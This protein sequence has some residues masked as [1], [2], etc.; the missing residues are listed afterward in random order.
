M[1][2]FQQQLLS[3]A[4]SVLGHADEQLLDARLDALPTG[5]NSEVRDLLV[6]AFEA[7]EADTLRDFFAPS[8]FTRW[9]AETAT[10]RDEQDLHAQLAL[11]LGAHPGGHDDPA[12]LSHVEPPPDELE[13]LLLWARPYGLLGELSQPVR[14]VLSEL[15]FVGDASLA[16]CLLGDVQTE[17]GGGKGLL[18]RPDVQTTARKYAL[19]QAAKHAALSAR[20]ELW[21]RRSHPALSK[22]AQRLHAV[23]G[24]VSFP[25]LHSVAFLPAKPVRLE[26]ATGVARAYVRG[27]ESGSIIDLRAFLSGYEQRAISIDCNGCRAR[28]CVHRRALA[29]RLL[30][31]CHDTGDALQVVLLEFVRIP[32]WQRF[33][34]EAHGAEEV[35]SRSKERVVF[36]I[37]IEGERASVGMLVQRMTP[38]GRFSQGKLAT[39]SQVTRNHAFE[40]RDRPVL[41]VL[42]NV[43][44]TLSA[45]FVVADLTLLRALVDHPLVFLD[46]SGESVRLSERSVEVELLEQ[47]E[48]LLPKVTLAGELVP[49]GARAA[50]VTY[51]MR[52][53]GDDL[54]FAA[55][56]PSLRRLL[57]ALDHFRGV[58]PPESYP[59]VA[60]WL[61]S[62]QAVAQVHVPK[63][64]AGHERPQLR[65][66]LLR[67][68]PGRDEGID[69]AIMVRALSLAALWLPG[70]GPELVHGFEDEKQAYV[71]RD[72]AWEREAAQRLIE[73]LELSRFVRLDPYAYRVE[74]RQEALTLLSRA[75]RLMEVL[76]IEWSER[77]RKLTLMTR[78]ATS[79][80]KVSL[81]RKGQWLSIEGKLQV[82]G[83]ELSVERLLEAV[84]R[85]ERFV[86]VQGN[87]YLEIEEQLFDRLA[88]AQL[89]TPPGRPSQLSVLAAPLWLKTVGDRSEAGDEETKLL[90]DRLRNTSNV[91]APLPVDF[92]PH[93]RS[94]QREGV[95]WLV[96]RSGWAPGVCLADEMGLGKTIQAAAL[97][98]LRG[99][100]GPALVITPTS[101][102]S[103]WVEA[104]TRFAP[105]LRAESYVGENRRAS[106]ENLSAQAVLVVSYETLLRD[107]EHFAKVAFATQVIDEAQVIRNARTLRAKAVAEVTAAFRVALSGTPVENR[108]GDLW[109]LFHLLTPG[110]LGPWSQFRARFAVPIERY[111]NS[112][113]S[114][115]LRALVRPFLLRRTKDE[116]ATE[117]PSRT[118]VIH[119]IE[120]SPAERDLY[121]AAERTARKALG[122]RSPDQAA[123][124][125]QILAEL[126]KLR[127]LSCHPRLVIGDER[128]GSSK[129]AAFLQLTEDI[130][131]RGH[132][133][134]VFSQFTRHLALVRQA[135]DE[136]A[137]TSLYL[138]GSTPAAERPG[139]VERFQN[140][141][142][143]VFLISLKAGGT[144]LNLTNADY[145][146]HMDPW[147]NPAAEDQASDRAHRIG[148]TKPL[149]IVKLVSE[150]TIEERVL[151]LHEHKRRLA[152][153]V[154]AGSDVPFS[155]DATDLEALLAG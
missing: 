27:S 110:L 32:S 147:W 37:R 80:L 23:V 120:L 76:D 62:L 50:D 74:S 114:D 1:S 136:A 121:E 57:A 97:L 29:A 133:V 47:P 137:V 93:L 53:H 116:V 8:T 30:D 115:A 154:L 17:P 117:L 60:P 5:L 83:A 96:E 135:L 2:P 35:R 16:A 84:V 107:R 86:Q 6:S 55:L 61:A 102:T 126:T 100:S 38:E 88:M 44:R 56:T 68:T 130:L 13:A 87:D 153:T 63:A 51:L 31:A 11:W 42:G 71:R 12:R 118:E 128:V 7:G 148:Q 150:G 149:T 79:D 131:R 112:E 81:F 21:K 134:L 138:D 108:L 3:M 34:R 143:D 139:L 106:L 10:Q 43:Q 155:V 26:P 95:A 67:V 91:G 145:V 22:L 45:R 98:A 25:T 90:L 4:A 9:L 151:A 18:S 142:A 123:R 49:Y 85:G 75:A 15:N 52:Q 73:A 122:K 144:G 77:S 103:Q 33:L 146:I 40:E 19:E 105:T 69:V 48:G 59:S 64:L 132:R 14:E 65:K 92:A 41:D 113:R 152:Q 78:V 129:L 66:L 94:Y 104:L 140:G 24:E 28:S 99:A 72:L 141:E 54:V 89:C 119:R 109:S 20:S 101:L 36:R 125:I 46:T 127:L 82:R 70:Q 124:S 58:L 39:A 111:E